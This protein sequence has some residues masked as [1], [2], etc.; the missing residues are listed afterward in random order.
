[1]TLK[2]CPVCKK[3]D[4]QVHQILGILPCISCQRRSQTGKVVKVVE[5]TSDSIKEDRKEYK[6][7]I[8][9]PFREGEVS[10]E[11]I[12]QYGTQGINVTQE[13]VKKAVP[14]TDSYY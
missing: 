3:N 7:D 10:K 9:Q 2:L 8:I 5:F 6:K 13:E 1:M 12:E 14:T 11:Y 4:S